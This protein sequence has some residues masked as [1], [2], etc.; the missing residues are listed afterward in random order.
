MLAASSLA[1]APVFW[2][3]GS[4]DLVAIAV[5]I[6]ANAVTIYVTGKDRQ[7]RRDA[8][9]VEEAWRRAAAKHDRI[10]SH[11]AR[12]I[13]A[14]NVIEQMTGPLSWKPDKFKTPEEM[15]AFRK[16]VDEMMQSMADA[17]SSLTTEGLKDQVDTINEIAV[18]FV[19]FRRGLYLLGEHEQQKEDVEKMLGAADEIR[20]LRE[21]LEQELPAILKELLPD[22]PT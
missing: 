20:K 10:Y 11:F 4:G 3:L 8:A 9:K 17:A 12:V 2:I 5:A 13:F 1:D 7:D 16:T 6:V 15:A 19:Q 21:K 14:T 22:K 18:K